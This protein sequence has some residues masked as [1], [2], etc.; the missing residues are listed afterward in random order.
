MSDPHDKVRSELSG[1]LADGATWYVLVD[2]AINDPLEE[3]DGRDQATPVLIQHQDLPGHFRPYLLKL[4]DIGRD[5]R[6]DRTIRI[7]VDE[8]T[9][10]SPQ[11]GSK[12]SICGW[13][14]S[15]HKSEAVASYLA[16][17]ARIA[18]LGRSRLL[19]IWDPRTLD[20]LQHLL[21]V[22]SMRTL[23]PPESRWW[24]LG[25][26]SAVKQLERSVADTG[27]E[28]QLPIDDKGVESLLLAESL[29][30]TLNVLQDMKSDVGPETVRIIMGALRRARSHWGVAEPVDLV[31]FALHARLVH[32]A[33]D[34]DEQVRLAMNASSSSPVRALSSFDE[35]AWSAVRERLSRIRN[36]VDEKEMEHHG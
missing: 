24:W 28:A 36:K 29:H 7:A 20:L 5:S 25:R 23:V 12:R 16:R 3:V 35:P 34:S 10:K 13:I 4:G 27:G 18:V 15:E 9:R 31:R 1:R 26:D 19:R 6:I 22:E 8:A 21:T 30:S 14:A 2:P 17:Q 33:F 11:N 32:E